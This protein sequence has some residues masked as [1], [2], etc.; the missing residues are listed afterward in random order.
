MHGSFA[1]DIGSLVTCLGVLGNAAMV[2]R[3]AAGRLHNDVGMSVGWHLGG[4]ASSAM[5]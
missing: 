1:S 3:C 2:Q 5:C 4:D